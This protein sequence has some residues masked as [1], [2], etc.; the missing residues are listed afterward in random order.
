MHTPW[1][2]QNKTE[3]TILIRS[4]YLLGFCGCL[5]ARLQC[6]FEKAGSSFYLSGRFSLMLAWPIRQH[7]QLFKGAPAARMDSWKPAS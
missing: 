1:V 2:L 7:K 3:Q 4:R 6:D 5:E